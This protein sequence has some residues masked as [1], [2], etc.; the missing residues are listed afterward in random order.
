MHAGPIASS[1]LWV[2]LEQLF[3]SKGLLSLPHGVPM[4]CR[5]QGIH[6]DFDSKLNTLA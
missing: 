4:L 3:H 5:R 2:T 6:V 1:A